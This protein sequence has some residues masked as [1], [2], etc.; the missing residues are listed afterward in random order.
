MKKEITRR[1]NTLIHYGEY[2]TPAF[3]Q[4]SIVTILKNQD[5]RRSRTS[6]TGP[7]SQSQIG[8]QGWAIRAWSSERV[9][10]TG[11]GSNV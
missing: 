1:P 8:Q 2:T 3:Q 9:W 10:T 5:A 4:N 7:V 6:K 11:N